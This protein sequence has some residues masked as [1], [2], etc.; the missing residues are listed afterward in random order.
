MNTL[1]LPLPSPVALAVAALAIAVLLA[2]RRR[3]KRS[4]NDDGGYLEHIFDPSCNIPP[5][6]IRPHPLLG[7]LPNVFS[8]PDD[9][10][11]S[12]GTLARTGAFYCPTLTRSPFESNLYS[13]R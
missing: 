1:Y 5:C 11:Y 9:E 2:A 8:P 3:I 12:S 7:H 6:R 4:R 10:R 13:L